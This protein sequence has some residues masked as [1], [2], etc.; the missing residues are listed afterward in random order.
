[1]PGST[2]NQQS[3]GSPRQSGLGNRARRIL[4]AI[5]AAY[6]VI[7]YLLLPL[8]WRE[9]E[10]RHPALQEIPR[11]TQTSSEIPGDPL[12]VALIGSRESLTRA[13]LGAGWYPADPL[14]LD[15]CLRIASDTVLRRPYVDAP[16]SNLYLWGRKQDLAFEQPVGHDPRQRHHVRYWCSKE[17]DGQGRPLWIGAA[18]F[19]RK[20][21]FSHTTGQITHHIG[22][23]IDLERDKIF[24][25][26][27][28]FGA[29]TSTDWIDGF[30]DTLDGHN[31]GGDRYHT[32]GRLEVGVLS[33]SRRVR[34]QA[35]AS[36]E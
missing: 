36:P 12:N 24:Q 19:D 28:A 16:V 30:H 35:G 4:V 25:D 31:G 3:A 23:D 15:S 2:T 33:E 9:V 17:L 20:V 7:A 6:L 29:L 13:M 21:G 1:M 32:D 34:V 10:G 8:I 14:T 27:Q 26:L 18:T 22:P 11:I 5:S